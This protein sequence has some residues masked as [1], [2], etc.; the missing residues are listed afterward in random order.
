MA[1][2]LQGNFFVPT[3][4]V[5]VL[6]ANYNGERFLA[7]AIVSVLEQ[8]YRNFELIVVDDG[9][10]DSSPAILRSFVSQD[11]RIKDLY[12]SHNRG[13]ACALNY[14]LT[15][16]RGEYV[17]RMDSDDLCHRDRLAKQVFYLEKNSEVY[18]LGCGYQNIDKHGLVVRKW[19]VPFFCG[20]AFLERCIKKGTYPLLHASFMARRFCLEELEGYREI[21]RIGEDLDLYAR[22]R[23][24]YG[25]V[26]KNLSKRLYYYRR[27]GASLTGASK[28]SEHALVRVLAHYS[29]ECRRL[30]IPDP[31][32]GA[33]DLSLSS[34]PVSSKERIV[35]LNRI[36]VLSLTDLPEERRTRLDVL[37][38]LDSIFVQEGY[39]PQFSHACVVVARA[40][41]RY[42]EWKFFALYIF[43]ALRIDFRLTISFLLYRAFL[44]LRL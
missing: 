38:R 35:L 32:S 13:F 1:Q 27:Y 24:R 5:S 20:R 3:P 22:M 26:F 33:Q 6:M 16:V 12:F 14:G 2:V 29:S 15:H 37:A 21:F 9:S 36:F 25:A 34:L 42:G 7:S 30:G 8:S 11:S 41:L 40:C 39:H 4:R 44:L 43:R 28:S 10:T 31:L 23:D 19:D 17:A 18:M